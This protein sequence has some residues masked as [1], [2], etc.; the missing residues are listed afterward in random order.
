MKTFEVEI[1]SDGITAKSINPLG[2]YCPIVPAPS[3]DMRSLAKR[4]SALKARREWQ[5]A[6]SERKVYRIEP[7][8]RSCWDCHDKTTALY[9]NKMGV[10]PRNN[11]C[12]GLKYKPNTIHLAQLIE[13]DKIRIL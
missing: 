5:Q 2:K 9:K 8:E 4:N 3:M 10:P 7:C 6:E 12:Y 13:G 11:P 1:C